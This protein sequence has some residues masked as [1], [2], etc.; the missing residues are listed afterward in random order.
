MTGHG[1]NRPVSA[2]I[3]RPGNSRDSAIV[4]GRMSATVGT[5]AL[6]HVLQ[7]GN[8]KV[9]AGVDLDLAGGASHDR[10]QV[11]AAR[12]NTVDSKASSS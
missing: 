4:Q 10:D 2:A 11:G 9:G 5:T 8:L 1:R 12:S 3:R 6:R 7:G